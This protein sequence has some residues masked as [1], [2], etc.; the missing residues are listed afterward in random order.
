M[1][2]GK[3]DL[4]GAQ[5]Q[6]AFEAAIWPSRLRSRLHDLILFPDVRPVVSAHDYDRS[7]KRS[8][9]SWSDT[10]V[11][12]RVGAPG[13]GDPRGLSSFIADLDLA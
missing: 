6:L 12:D 11:R 10:F 13:A 1:E 8:K 2:L 7:V 3:P 5:T 4:D 9:L